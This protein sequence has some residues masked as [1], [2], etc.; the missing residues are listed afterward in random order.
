[1]PQRVIPPPPTT[2]VFPARFVVASGVRLLPFTTWAGWAPGWHIRPYER[3]QTH[4]YLDA[5]GQASNGMTPGG[6]ATQP[7]GPG[8]S[9]V[10]G[11]PWV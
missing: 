10:R 3:T 11:G 8:E 2:A 7:P 4:A 1:L 9:R 6:P 5:K